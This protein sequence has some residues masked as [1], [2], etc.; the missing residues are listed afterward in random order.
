MPVDKETSQEDDRKLVERV[1]AGDETA[2]EQLVRKYQQNVFSLV[3]HN[4]GYRGDVEDVAQKIFVKI[5]LSLPKFDNRRP[6]FPWLYRIAVN[7]CYD[8]LRRIKRHKVHT[9]TELSLED[10]ESIEKLVAQNDP[11][12]AP[13]GDRT[14]L[15]ALLMK[16]MDKLP[17]QQRMAIILRD[18]EDI[19]YEKLSQ[20]MDCSEQ[21][22]R[23]KV[24]RGRNRLRKLIEKAIRRN[25]L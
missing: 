6:F 11:G 4:L 9:F 10:S 17:A 3:H 18:L 16:L 22:V 8:E 12:P 15:T 20:M 2:F 14:Q 25:Q 7:Q 1:K 23:L 5:Y 21:A 19:P 24:F 13:S